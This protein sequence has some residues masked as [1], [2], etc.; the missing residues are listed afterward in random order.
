MSTCHPSLSAVHIVGFAFQITTHAVLTCCIHVMVRAWLAAIFRH[1]FGAN[2]VPMGVAVTAT[3]FFL[4][5]S[6]C[7]VV[8]Q[9]FGVV[10]RLYKIFDLLIF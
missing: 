1:V 7:V 8:D 9:C 5:P 6:A 10:H 2:Q 4:P 3:V